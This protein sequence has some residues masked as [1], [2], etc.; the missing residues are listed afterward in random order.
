M[1]REPRTGRDCRIN[2][3]C[4]PIGP[5]LAEQD[6]ALDGPRKLDEVEGFNTAINKLMFADILTDA[7]VKACR[8]RLFKKHIQ[9]HIVEL[10]DWEPLGI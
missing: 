10:R 6:C 8:E 5:Q 9:G 7:Q 2:L 4:F 3:G 1:A